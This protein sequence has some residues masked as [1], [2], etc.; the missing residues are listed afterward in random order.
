MLIDAGVSE[1]VAKARAVMRLTARFSL[2][3]IL[4]ACRAD[5]AVFQAV[6]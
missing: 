1:S 5:L 3:A 2:A 6:A 4:V